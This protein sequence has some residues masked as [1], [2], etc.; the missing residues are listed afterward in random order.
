[1]VRLVSTVSSKRSVE[2]CC[3]RSARLEEQ[4]GHLTQVEVDEVFGLVSH[5]T[6]EVPSHDAMPGGV[7]LFV[8]LLHGK[9][10]FKVNQY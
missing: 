10:T 5:V 3:R 8:E 9:N 6:P 1:M 7:V 4:D 2:S